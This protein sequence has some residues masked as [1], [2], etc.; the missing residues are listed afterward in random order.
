MKL[1]DFKP[2]DT[3]QL[4]EGGP[5]FTLVEHLPGYHPAVKATTYNTKL[6]QQDE[7]TFFAHF[8]VL[9]VC[10]AAHAGTRCI[11]VSRDAENKK[12]QPG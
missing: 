6:Q 11:T 10:F 4:Q 3:F 1:S 9:P 12:G 2:G 5:V 8:P 7:H